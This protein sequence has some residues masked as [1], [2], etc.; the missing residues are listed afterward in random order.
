MADLV[1]VKKM[2]HAW[3]RNSARGLKDVR[4]SVVFLSEAALSHRRP[5]YLQHRCTGYSQPQHCAICNT[6]MFLWFYFF[7]SFVFPD[8]FFF[9]FFFTPLAVH[10]KICFLATQH[11]IYH[12]T[13]PKH[14]ASFCFLCFLVEHVTDLPSHNWGSWENVCRSETAPAGKGASRSE[15]SAELRRGQVFPGRSARL[16]C[17][18]SIPENCPKWVCFQEKHKTH[19]DQRRTGCTYKKKVKTLNL[20]AT[21]LKVAW[22]LLGSPLQT[23]CKQLELARISSAKGRMPNQISGCLQQ[24]FPPLPGCYHCPTLQTAVIQWG[25]ALFNAHMQVVRTGLEGGDPALPAA[26]GAVQMCTRRRLLMTQL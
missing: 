25:Q 4:L 1:L 20:A 21:H 15:N 9:L 22:T 14:P 6:S 3:K 23:I 19:A 10:F 8:F 26:L 12:L 5:V 24:M 18:R 2:E 13:V 7:L 17:C 11:L 16:S